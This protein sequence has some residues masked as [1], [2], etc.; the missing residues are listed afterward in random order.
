MR[1]LKIP[2]FA[3]ALALAVLFS[4]SSA[5]GPALAIDLKDMIFDPGQLKPVD[6]TLKVRPGQKAPDFVLPST[7]GEKVRLSDYRGKKNVVLSFVPAAFT[8]VC[9]DQWPGYKLTRDLFEERDAVILGISVD[10]VPALYAW[11]V[12]MHGL[13][14]P[15]LSDFPH[16]AVA[17]KYGL[18]RTSG[19]S[20]R[21]IVIIDKQGVIRFA[22]AFDINRRP[23][24]GVIMGELDKLPK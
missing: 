10:N 18:L 8:P 6:S 3:A 24:L 19:T 23:D 22:K 14:F 11:V 2:L 17:R 16:G 12:E 13:W 9:S 15:V 4:V 1:Q 5:P 21:A 20:E 7:T